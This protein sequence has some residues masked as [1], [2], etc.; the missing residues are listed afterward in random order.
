[1][2]IGAF[3]RVLIIER[4]SPTG[5]EDVFGQPIM[6]WREIA[7]VWAEKLHKS[8]DEAFAASQRYATRTV[9]FRTYW[10]DDVRPT[11]RLSS[12]SLTYNIKGIRE[13]GFREGLE[14]SAD[15][16]E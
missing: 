14:I 3:D 1:M 9:T 13:I 8:E 12:D 11:D 6:E 2:R 15:W 4:E 5:E 16:Q 10:L 7:R